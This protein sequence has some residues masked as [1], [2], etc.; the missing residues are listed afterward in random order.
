MDDS[1]SIRVRFHQTDGAFIE[2]DDFQA[3]EIAELEKVVQAM[4]ERRSAS[5][6]FLRR[7]WTPGPNAAPVVPRAQRSSTTSDANDPRLTRGVDSEP[8]EQADVYLVLS[9]ADRAKGYTRPYRTKYVH[10]APES[11]KCGVVTTMGHAIAETYARD[12]KFYGGTYCVGCRMHRPLAEFTWDDG[13]GQV[14]G[15]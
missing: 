13:S 8:V 4:W 3:H 15:S 6:D 7:G 5:P 9:E 12:P 11:G 2:T 1:L 10:S 14:V